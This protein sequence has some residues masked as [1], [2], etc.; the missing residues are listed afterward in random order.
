MITDNVTTQIKRIEKDLAF[1]KDG[2]VTVKAASV[3]AVINFVKSLTD[4]DK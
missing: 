4:N 1:E 2:L 3:I